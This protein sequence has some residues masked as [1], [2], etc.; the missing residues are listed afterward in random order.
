MLQI[1]KNFLK[2]IEGKELQDDYSISK[3]R[4]ASICESSLICDFQDKF[5]P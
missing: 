4:N 2:E 3:L 1:E 5:I